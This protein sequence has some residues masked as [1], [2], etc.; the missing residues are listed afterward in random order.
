MI[1]RWVIT[2]LCVLQVC[3]AIFVDPVGAQ[4]PVMTSSPRAAPKDWKTFANADIGFSVRHPA[5]YTVDTS[6][7]PDVGD[8]R[9]VSFAVPD[10]YTSGTN[11]LQ[12]SV[13][14][15]RA[16]DASA[17]SAKVVLPDAANV[18]DVAE[19]GMAY[20]VADS[21]EGAAMPAIDRPS[22]WERCLSLRRG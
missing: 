13:A 15:E 4:S 8:M 6:Y 3:A 18:R 1:G 5:G 16:K 12:A 9:G 10:S 19:N 20:S 14:I 11:L 22:R 17:C 2:A 21:T 7:R